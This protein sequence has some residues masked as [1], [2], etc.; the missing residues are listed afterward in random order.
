MTLAQHQVLQA[1][2]GINFNFKIWSTRY[3]SD[4]LPVLRVYAADGQTLYLS[5]AEWHE[6]HDEAIGT[7]LRLLD[8]RAFGQKKFVG[9]GL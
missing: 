1:R 5:D 4:Q 7:G 2:Q 6:E 3:L 9:K 8:H